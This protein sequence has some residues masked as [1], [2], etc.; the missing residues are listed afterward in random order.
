VVVPAY[1][2][3]GFLH[4][5][6]PALWRSTLPR[7]EWE[8]I[9]VDD[10]SPDDTG[11][12]AAQYADRVVRVPDGP[13]GPALAR[14]LGV[15]EARASTVLF[16]DADVVVH[17]DALA[18]VVA[19]F[20]A[21]PSLVAVFG[22]YDD[23]PRAPGLVSQY[24][25]LLHR[26]VHM[27][28]AGAATTFW[29][30]CGA[31]R[32]DAFLAIGGFDAARFPRPQVEDID[33]GYRLHDRGGAIRIDP[34]ISGTHLKQ[35]TLGAMLRTD[36][37]D[38]AIPWMRLL[39]ARDPVLADGPLN[40]NRLEQGF[41]LATAVAL[42]SL[43]LALLTGRGVWLAV[44][45]AALLLVTVGNLPLFVWFARTRSVPF[46]VATVPLRWAFYAVSAVGAGWAVVG[47][48][49]GRSEPSGPP[50]TPEPA[51]VPS[52]APVATAPA[53]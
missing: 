49:T 10:G 28:H 30:G 6:L 14:N 11:A 9:V 13:R 46:A 33:L 8:L 52:D 44:A 47:H 32:R 38:R 26:H 1:R 20:A 41:V 15:R 21:D 51:A 48:F 42:G 22:A 7:D 50:R 37:R 29:A 40:A 2:C 31:V 5:C 23:Q 12:V 24:R 36:L 25:N 45:A 43:T 39:L 16:V 53:P 17:P 3:P 19:H 34:A 18:R 4:E 27:A 35:W